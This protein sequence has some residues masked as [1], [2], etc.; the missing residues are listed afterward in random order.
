MPEPLQPLD[1]VEAAAVAKVRHILLEGQA[2]HQRRAG[3]APPLVQRVG[4]P[5][6]H[7]VVGLAAGKDHLRVVAEP[8]GQMAEVIRIDP[9]AVAA[10]QPG[11]EGEEVPLGPRRVEHVPHRHPDLREKICATSFMKAMLMS[12]W[13][14]S[15]ALAAFG[16]LDRRRAEHPAAGDRAID[17]RELLDHLLVLA[18]DDLG[19]LV[20]AVL[21]VA[22]VDP[23][24][25]VAEAEV[26]AALQPPTRSISGP[27]ISSVTPG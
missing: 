3:L 5:R 25:A 12:R 10:D 21:A 15:I 1:Q 7:P 11:L 18:G 2:E 17:L 23:L 13:A 8:L 9:D 4:D 20:D 22:R 19:D 27:Q 16:G 24:G 26:A 14:F 6:A